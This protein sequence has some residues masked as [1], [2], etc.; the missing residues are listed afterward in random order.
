[1]SDFLSLTSSPSLS[2]LTDS[3]DLNVTDLIKKKERKKKAIITET[4]LCGDVR[5]ECDSYLLWNVSAVIIKREKMIYLSDLLVNVT[6]AFTAQNTM[7]QESGVAQRILNHCVT[8]IGDKHFF[9][10]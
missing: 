1:M 4:G 7:L 9:L 3:Q 2:C 5:P 8:L 10:K 6:R